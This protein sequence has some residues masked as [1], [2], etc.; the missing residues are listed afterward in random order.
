VGDRRIANIDA[1]ADQLSFDVLGGPNRT[2]EVHGYAPTA[3][4]RVEAA[5]LGDRRTVARGSDGES[6]SWEARGGRWILRL[7][8]G[9]GGSLRVHLAW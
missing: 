1:T 7:A 4:S 3:P 2:V 8:L 6:W 9:R 5:P